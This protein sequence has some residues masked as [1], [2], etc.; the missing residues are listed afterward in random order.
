MYLIGRVLPMLPHG[1]CNHLC[2]LNPNEPKLSFSAF[3]RLCKRSGNLI[4]DPAPWFAKTAI[5]SVCRL[6]YD[7]AQEVID[8]IEIEETK[9]PAVHGGYTW[10]EIKDDIKLLYEVCGKVRMGRLTGGAMTISKTKMIFHTMDSE[11]GIPTG[12]HLES[13]SA[14]HWVIEEL[15]LL[16]NR[17]VATRLFNSAIKDFSVL[18]NHKPPENKKAQTLQKLMRER[19]G[20][21]DFDM[22]CAN[23][24]YKSCQDIYEKHG[25]MLGLCVEM[26]VMRAGM[27]QAEYFVCGVDDEE[28]DEPNP[29]HF[30]LNFDYY[31]HF[32]SPIRRYPDVMVHRV[33]H[34]LLENQLK[35]SERGESGETEVDDENEDEDENPTR[36]RYF[37]SRKRAKEQVKI[38]NTKKVNSRRCQEQLDRAVFCIFLRSM[39]SWFYTVGTVLSLNHSAR[40]GDGISIYC[41]QLGRESKVALRSQDPEDEESNESKLELFMNGVDDELMLPKNWEWQGR[42]GIQI[43]WKSPDGSEEHIQKLQMLSC[44]PIVIIPTNTVP[45]DYAMFLVSPFHKKFNQVRKDIAKEEVDGFAWADEEDEEGVETCYDA[46]GY[47]EA[48]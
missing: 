3:F 17:C 46:S 6:N 40:D 37:Q 23:A 27:Q 31:T 41:S 42:G 25:K 14:S 15:M 35:P 39:K 43:T 9:R 33:L 4:Q 20:I 44:A 28:D 16:A 5:S 34:A 18:R 47:P 19:L 7:Q 22:S 1:L 38:C 21:K 13:H 36:T 45:I 29:H 32:T 8:D 30:A 48:A 12:Y 11:D 2:S 26:M 10:Q 24:I